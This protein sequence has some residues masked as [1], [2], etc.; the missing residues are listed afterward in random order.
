MKITQ[1]SLVAHWLR[2]HVSMAES[3]GSVPSRGAKILHASWHGPPPQ[4]KVKLTAVVPSIWCH[5]QYQGNCVHMS[6]N[7][8][9]SPSG[10]SSLK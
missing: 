10:E 7:P 9:S 8:P 1:A 3:T 6:F 4:K 2:L 5:A